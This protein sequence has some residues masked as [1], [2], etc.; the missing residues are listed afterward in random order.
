MR[1]IRKNIFSLMHR[2][3]QNKRLCTQILLQNFPVRYFQVL[4]AHAETINETYVLS[5]FEA[6]RLPVNSL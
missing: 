6:K 3:F 4:N 1:D 2:D 5:E